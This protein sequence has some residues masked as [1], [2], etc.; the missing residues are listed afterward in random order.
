MAKKATKQSVEVTKSVAP[1][2]FAI[3]SG[4]SIPERAARKSKYPFAQLEDGQS[5]FVPGIN[6]TGLYSSAR[7]FARKRGGKFVVRSVEEGGV[8]GARVWR[9]E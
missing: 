8:A 3:E 1:S 9:V 4:I 6:K 7:A 5:F 2:A